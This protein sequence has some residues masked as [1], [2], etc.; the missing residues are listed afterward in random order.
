MASMTT[1]C[2]DCVN[3]LFNEAMFNEA[4]RPPHPW[5][6]TSRPRNEKGH[7]HSKGDLLHVGEPRPMLGS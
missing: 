4:M 5:R 6:I 3:G 2:D 7:P 1:V